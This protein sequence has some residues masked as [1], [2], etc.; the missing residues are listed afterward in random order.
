MASIMA[1][2]M[3]TTERKVNTEDKIDI[4]SLVYD[5]GKS[6]RR[7]IVLI[8]TVVSLAASLFYG[9]AMR[10]YVP[11][12]SSSA[13]VIINLKSAVNYND[14]FTTYYTQSATRQITQTFPYIASS[15]VLKNKIIN[16]Y[17]AVAEDAQIRA[18]ELEDLNMITLR[19]STGSPKL[20]YNIL[21]SV[22]D[23]YSD[24][25][26]SVIGET[27]ITVI[28]PAQVPTRA[29]NPSQPLAKARE[30][31]LY[32]LAAVIA[33]LFLRSFMKKTV[34]SEDDF[35]RY[36]SVKSL[37]GLP[38][39]RAKREEK[40]SEPL[41]RLDGISATYAYRE[42]AR[43]LRSR[44]ERDHAETGAKVYMV[45]SALAGEGK[46][47]V[48]SNLAISLADKGYSV[49]LI[50]MDLRNSSILEVM[51]LPPT[52]KGLADLFAGEA[53]IGDI[54]VVDEK[55]GVTILPGGNAGRKAIQTLSS[56]RPAQLLEM[57]RDEADYI[58]VDTPPSGILSDAATI[59]STVDAG[60]FVIRQDYAPVDRIL[61]GIQ[62]LSETGLRIVGCVLNNVDTGIVGGYG[63]YAR[64]GY[65]RYGYGYGRY[66]G[67]YGYGYGRYSGY[68]SGK[69]RPSSQN[70]DGSETEHGETRRMPFTSEED[71]S[72]E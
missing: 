12:Y 60:I 35:P 5:L 52:E 28:T 32:A 36:L 21:Q 51:G 23:N 40:G 57:A 2:T 7:H 44:L 34:R 18:V 10:S 46:S 54:L 9:M 38:H 14:S 70:D 26:A 39:V 66:Y 65:G 49:L 55:S 8:L 15:G 68:G 11:R 50:D 62:M 53:S 30:G 43:T 64:Y 3:E 24:I 72:D 29:D 48:S 1:D 33:L 20:S 19:V 45:S 71:D 56:D 27:E 16:E 67:R 37:G 58:I 4:S 63:R 31:A 41:V 42:A 17:G 61:E 69:H 6:L 22:L 59:V 47:T 25:A 13:T